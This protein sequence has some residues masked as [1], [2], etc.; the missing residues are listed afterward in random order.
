MDTP[1][2]DYNNVRIHMNLEKI[3][4]S[5]YPN[6]QAE[7]NGEYARIAIDLSMIEGKLPAEKM[8]EVFEWVKQNYVEL[9]EGWMR[10]IK[11][12]CA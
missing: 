3:L 5:Y 6:V 1:L 8:V 11:K 4:N 10:M 12:R 9:D 7:Y 2:Y